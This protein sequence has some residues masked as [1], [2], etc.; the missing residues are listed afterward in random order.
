MHVSLY[1]ENKKPE[2][3]K[4]KKLGRLLTERE[5]KETGED[6]GMQLAVERVSNDFLQRTMK[7]KWFG[8]MVSWVKPGSMEV[9]RKERDDDEQTFLHQAKAFA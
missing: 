3:M 4:N 2:K 9:G 1:E 6:K 8:G 5:I 7:H